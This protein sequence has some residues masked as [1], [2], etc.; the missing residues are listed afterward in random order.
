MYGQPITL[1]APAFQGALRSPFTYDVQKL[2]QLGFTPRTDLRAEIRNMLEYCER[3][4][5]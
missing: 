1:E 3:F 5:R 4:G 2:E